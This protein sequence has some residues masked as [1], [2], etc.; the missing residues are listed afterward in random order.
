ML[1][2]AVSIGARWEQQAALAQQKLA[3]AGFDEVRIEPGQPIETANQNR[4]ACDCF[5]KI[6][7]NESRE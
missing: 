3:A 5:P 4:E 6:L 1:F 2:I 7:E